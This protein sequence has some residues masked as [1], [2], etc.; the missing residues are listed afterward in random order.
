M[1]PESP[2]WNKNNK[3]AVFN[4]IRGKLIEL[5][6]ADEFCSITIQ[7]GHENKRVV[8]FI[9]KKEIFNQITKQHML[10]DVVSVKYYIV[11]RMK[12]GRYYTNANV[13]EVSKDKQIFQ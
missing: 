8:N 5:N 9:A 7:C 1:E 10:E 3:Q 6:D 11:S 12:N 4:S 2:V 13:L